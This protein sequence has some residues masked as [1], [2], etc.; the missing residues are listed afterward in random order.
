M[1][2]KLSKNKPLIWTLIVLV[3]ALLYQNCAPPVADE[4]STG[5]SSNADE[6]PWA[7]KGS[8]LDTFAH[9]SCPKPSEAIVYF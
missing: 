9:L 5:L 1:I 6:S 4:G 8:K 2:F 7:Y 3:F